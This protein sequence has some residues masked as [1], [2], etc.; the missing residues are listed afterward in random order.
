MKSIFA[1][2]ALGLIV[3]ACAGGYSFE[4]RGYGYGYEG[5]RGVNT[6][7]AYRQDD[8]D[9]EDEEDEIPYQ[10]VRGKPYCPKIGTPEFEE[11]NG[12]KPVRPGFHCEAT[13]KIPRQ[14]CGGWVCRR[15][16]G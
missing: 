16:R 9:E 12:R 8:A 10:R 15:I 11:V 2:F 4:R 6:Q 13:D 5:N 1:V 7:V 3:S 14:P